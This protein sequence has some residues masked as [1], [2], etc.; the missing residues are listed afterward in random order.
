MFK[1]LD[2]N[3]A[4]AEIS[5][6][7]SDEKKDYAILCANQA[8]ENVANTTYGDIAKS[9]KEA[10]ENKYGGDWCCIVL[11]V[12]ELGYIISHIKNHSIELVLQELRIL[13]FKSQV[14]GVLYICN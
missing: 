2:H 3:W 1:V 6:E 9:I 8:T 7:I 14:N 11:R 10:F 5:A 13:L 12:A 4:D